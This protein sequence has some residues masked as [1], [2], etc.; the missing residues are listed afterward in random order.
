MDVI[1]ITTRA[2]ATNRRTAHEIIREALEKID[3]SVE[4]VILDNV[5][6]DVAYDNHEALTKAFKQQLKQMRSADVIFFE[7]S[8]A[9]TNLGYYL[10]RATSINKPVVIF[11]RA[12]T[13]PAMLSLVEHNSDKTTAVR[14]HSDDELYEEVPRAIEFVSEAQDTRFNFFLSPA[15]SN[16]LDWISKTQKMPRS[17]FLRRL[18][19]EDIERNE[20]YRS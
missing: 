16:Y 4:E 7:T 17:V 19:D 14:Y 6:Q 1:L 12:D 20:D 15:L 2:N 5:S 10:A 13:E 9:D 8:T 11:H 3:A 18:I